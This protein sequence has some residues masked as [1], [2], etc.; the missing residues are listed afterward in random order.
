MN[1]WLKVIR[2]CCGDETEFMVDW[3][4]G[5]ILNPEENRPYLYFWGPEECGKSTIHYAIGLLLGI[6]QYRSVSSML[7]SPHQINTFR[8][9]FNTTL[10]VVEEGHG[11]IAQLTHYVQDSHIRLHLAGSKPINVL[12]RTNWIECSEIH[13]PPPFAKVFTVEPLV[14]I[15]PHKEMMQMLEEEKDAFLEFII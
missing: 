12:N 13:N 10:C 3:I 5:L 8:Y 15:I 9:L 11:D 6:G 14:E 1:T 2:H 7:K 4:R